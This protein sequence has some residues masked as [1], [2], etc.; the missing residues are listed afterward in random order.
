MA[1]A[2]DSEYVVCSLSISSRFQWWGVG[3][4]SPNSTNW[5][6]LIS[7]SEIFVV[8]S[9]LV[10]RDQ[11]CIAKRSMV[12]ILMNIANRCHFIPFVVWR[13]SSVRRCLSHTYHYICFIS[14]H[15]CCKT[16]RIFMKETYICVNEFITN[17]TLTL[18]GFT[19]Y[20]LRIKTYWL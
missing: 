17:A 2:I 5:A 16:I 10:W 9:I 1:A 15:F 3:Y 7:L 4:L 12:S 14:P 6:V 8:Q 19:S 13:R 18:F 20:P 11:V